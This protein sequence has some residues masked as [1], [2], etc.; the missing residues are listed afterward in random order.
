M[1]QSSHLINDCLSTPVICK[2]AGYRLGSYSYKNDSCNKSDSP[3]SCYD[4]DCSMAA[5]PEV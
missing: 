2:Q 5:E 4:L 1:L 3:E